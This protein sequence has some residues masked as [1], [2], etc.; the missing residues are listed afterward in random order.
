MAEI[1]E[2]LTENNGRVA[3]VTGRY[4]AMDRDRRWDRTQM[5]Y[6]AILH[7]RAEQPDAPTHHG[8]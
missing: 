7:G 6:D 1:E 3:T 4:Y 8:E 5:A 2:L